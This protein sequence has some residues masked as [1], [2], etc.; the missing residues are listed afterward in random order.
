MSSKDLKKRKKWQ[1]Y[2]GANAA[3]AE[4][5]FYKNLK[6]YFEKNNS[7]LYVE[8]KP[9]ELKSIYV[10]F[11]LDNM[12]QEEI[13]TP[14][15]KIVNHGIRPDYVIRNKDN[16]KSLYVEVKRQDGWV[17]GKT[18]Y[19]GRGNA[20]ERSCKFFTPGLLAELRKYG[21]ISNEYLPFWTVFQGDISRDPCRVREVSLWYKGFEGHFFFWRPFHTADELISHFEKNLEHIIR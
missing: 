11:P 1:D 15:Q 14:D 21:N 10:D 13:Y 16:D 12:T 17:E 5:D 4:R 9:P 19:D 6:E 20:H 2:S 3:K 18:R 7:S 8:P